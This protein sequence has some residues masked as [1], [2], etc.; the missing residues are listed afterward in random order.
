EKALKQKKIKINLKYFDFGTSDI[1]VIEAAKNAAKSDVLA[2]IG[3]AYSSHA[4]LAGPIHHAAKLPMLTCAS[5]TKI[6][7]IGR[8]SHQYC[9]SNDFEGEALAKVAKNK[10]K[11][12]KVLMIPASDCSFC[13]DLANSFEKH[14]VKSENSK[15]YR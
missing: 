8:Y 1:K 12:E 11:A 10:L 2:T 6:E 9:L 13:E 14:F 3:Y 7:E 15:V 5:S 4:L